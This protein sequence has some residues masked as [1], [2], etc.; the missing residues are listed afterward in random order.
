MPQLL[1]KPPNDVAPEGAFEGSLSGP[2]RSDWVRTELAAGLRY[3]FSLVGVGEDPLLDPFVFLYDVAGTQ[4]ASDDDGGAGLNSLL[5]FEPIATGVYYVEASKFGTTDGGTYSL[6]IRAEFAESD[7]LPG[8]TSSM[9]PLSV[10]RTLR[11]DITDGSDADWVQ[12]ALDPE[13]IYAISVD[14]LALP[15]AVVTLYDADGTAIAQADDSV[16]GSFDPSL[17]YSV[18]SPGT[19]FAGVS[20]ATELDTGTYRLGLQTVDQ[21][22]GVTAADADDVLIGTDIANSFLGGGGSDTILGNGGSDFIRGGTGA[23][24]LDG[25]EGRDALRGDAGADVLRGQRGQDFLSGNGGRDTLLGGTGSDSL[26][27]GAK[28]DRLTGGGGDDTLVGGRGNDTLKGGVGA[29]VFAFAADQGSDRVRDFDLAEDRLLFEIG[30]VPRQLTLEQVMDRY[31]SVV[32]GN[33][34][35]AFKSGTTVTLDGVTDLAALAER[36]DILPL[37]EVI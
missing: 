33:A 3:E 5:V 11:G 35:L 16:S 24:D 37:V 17:F 28:S 10:N 13:T 2:D 15:D 6:D 8:D 22:F 29:D 32:D 23:D 21:S 9:T 36:I 12:V 7:D 20:G 31:A 26:E 4:I 25:G 19:Y 30:L 34:V 18:T 1:S 27:G 14:G